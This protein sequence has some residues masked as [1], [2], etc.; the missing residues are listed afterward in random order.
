MDK[1]KDKKH[2]I[3][4]QK[5]LLSCNWNRH[6]KSKVHQQNLN[7]RAESYSA[8]SDIDDDDDELLKFHQKS[9]QHRI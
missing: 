6:A 8:S 5:H 4:C 3:V 1:E 2:S 9:Y 7:I